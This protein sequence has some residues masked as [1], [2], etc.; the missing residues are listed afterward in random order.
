MP[1]LLLWVALA[2]ILASCGGAETPP[3]N[4]VTIA[5]D[6]PPVNLDPRVGTDAT[7]ARLSE[8]IFSSLVKKNERSELDPD[9]ATH[10][11][12]PTPTT[13][14]FH[15]RPNVRFHDGR[16]VT[17]KD[18]LY[19][20][21][22]VLESGVRTV[23]TGTYRI[24]EKVE[25][26]DD[27]TV[28]FTLREPFAPFLWNLS[29]GAI[30]IVPDGAPADFA[31]T[32]IGSGPFKF[33]RYVQDNEVVLERNEQYY[34]SVPKVREVRFK[35][36]PEAVT[37][38]LELRKGS[39]DAA[40]NVLTPDMVE[41]L[42]KRQDLRV[43][44][45]EGTIYQYI[46]F[47]LQDPVFRDVRVRKAIAYAIDR[48]SIIRHLWRNQAEA[49]TGVI[50]PNNWCYEPNVATYAYD[51]EKARSL[52]A[53]A[54]QTRLRFTFRTSNDDV[55]RLLAAVL[56]QQLKA[57]GIEMDIKSNEFATF[58]A[59]VVKG[60]FQA[61]SLRWIGG[62][63]DPDI[64]NLIFHSKMIPPNGAN[65][66]RYANTRVDTLIEQGQREVDFAVRKARYAEIQRI[67]A[68][69][70][71]YV[72]LWYVRNVCVYNE[73]VQGMKLYPAGGF[74]FLND[75]SLTPATSTQLR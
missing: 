64:F 59:D 29:T 36:I 35:I 58:Y 74:E 63:N 7:G 23:K 52:L 38:A 50:P 71:P 8:L 66:G 28:R 17:A 25:S 22:S 20:F 57:I 42:R 34:G 31:K 48:E 33:V 67:V 4:V 49:A 12:I 70:L 39:V 69:E 27:L 53:E 45:A 54:G 47:N 9:L 1:A 60:N 68:D 2:L 62:N 24:I 56:Q 6:N 32:P 16:P 15:L 37:R 43:V 65:R 19:T 75:I 40:L 30:G 14:V 72:S 26:L 5:L 46:A 61:Y 13:Y 55:A 51:P 44:E 3:E 18:V 41:V 10:W 21:N 11:E 73:R